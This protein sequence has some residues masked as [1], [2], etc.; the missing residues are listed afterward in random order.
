MSGLVVARSLHKRHDVAVFEKARGVGGRIATRYAGAYEFDH[1]AQ[2][3][4]ARSEEFQA[5]LKP[6]LE[7]G[8]IAPWGARFAERNRDEIG[9][10]RQW[11][12]DFPHYV[13]VPRMNAVCKWLAKGL[14]VRLGTA[15]SKL[16]RD[17]RHWRL[18][19]EPG[20]AVGEFDW[21]VMTAP[22]G[23][24]AAL[25]PAE[26]P[27]RQICAGYSMQ[28]CFALL[29]GFA[30]PLAFPVDATRVKDADISWISVNNSKPGRPIGCSLLVH[31]TNAWADAHLDDDPQEI[32]GHLMRE[33]S[34]VAGIRAHDAEY[35]ELHRWRY[36]NIGAQQGQPFA[37]DHR[38][39]LA[40]AGDWFARGR[41]EGAF[42]SARALS[43]EL[44][45]L[46]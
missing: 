3:F 10:I 23:Q 35:V 12:S 4:T 18:A 39:G 43:T 6:L 31:S 36:A 33:V 45:A 41:V 15:V 29:L 34:D 20:N 27:L 19:A 1:G 5:F 28:A 14:D 26:S 22:A 38:N 32:R 40:A 17:D 46:D 13:G 21:V 11:G 16:I 7:K 44:A 30:E 2:F 8:V 42:H 37:I 25:C 9:K 24:T